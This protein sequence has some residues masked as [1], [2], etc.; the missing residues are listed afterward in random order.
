MPNLKTDSNKDPQQDHF[1][2]DKTNYVLFGIGLAFIAL[3]F[4][5][6]AGGGSEDPNVYNE[7]LF[8]AQRIVVAPILIVI[9]FVV[10]VFG[11]MRR[12]KA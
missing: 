3:G 5:L 9:G 4:V 8:S 6:M 10:E 7:D 11:I 2:F 12:P 1:L